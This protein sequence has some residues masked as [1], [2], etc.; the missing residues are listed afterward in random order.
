MDGLFNLANAVDQRW[1]G[2]YLRVLA[3]ILIYGASVH[4]GNML[5]L[6][7]TAW[8]DTPVLW[9]V[10]DVVLLVFNAVVAVG[11]WLKRPWAVVSFV[12]GIVL[13]QIVPY[14]LFRQHFMRAPEDAGAL[15][16]LVGTLLLLLGILV[17]LLVAKK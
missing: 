6:T 4:V 17:V 10:M 3:A 8:G 14:T 15:T 9:R 7:G 5:G 12:V 11:L 1:T 2:I 13:L 16:G